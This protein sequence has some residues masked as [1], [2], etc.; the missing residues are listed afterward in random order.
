MNKED[1]PLFRDISRLPETRGIV[2]FPISLSNIQTTQHPEKIAEDVYHIFLKVQR[3]YEGVLLI[4]LYADYLYLYDERPAHEMRKYIMGSVYQ[5]RGALKKLLRKKW[6]DM[7]S[8]RFMTYGELLYQASF[9]RYFEMLVRQYN[10]DELLRKCVE[11][12]AGERTFGDLQRDFILEES[13]WLHLINHKILHLNDRYHEWVLGTY[14]G[15]MLATEIYLLQKNPFKLS[16][17]NYFADGH[18]NL[19]DKTLE[20]GQKIDLDRLISGEQVLRMRKESGDSNLDTLPD[21]SDTIELMDNDNYGKTLSA[22]KDFTVGSI[23]YIPYGAI[24]TDF[25]DY[26]IP[27]GKTTAVES[28]YPD[29]NISGYINHSCDPT[30]YLGEKS[31]NKAFI[32]MKDITKGEEITTHYALLGYEFGNEWP[33]EERMCK[34]GSDNCAGKVRAWSELSRDERLRLAPYAL[35]HLLDPLYNNGEDFHPYATQ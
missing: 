23:V 21:N 20:R 8:I 29:E 11:Y 28:R 19:R 12:D 13:L 18:Y 14:P 16:S 5:H 32:A 25:N 31:G 2:Y 4:F 33:E 22:R 3:K 34:C 9:S 15:P 26:T 27:F 7:Q 17:N 35:P 1:K 30:V 10:S 24:R 6:F